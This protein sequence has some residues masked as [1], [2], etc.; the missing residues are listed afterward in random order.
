MQVSQSTARPV[1]YIDQF[2]GKLNVLRAPK[3]RSTLSS[4]WLV[5]LNIEI[6]SLMAFRAV[7][8]WPSQPHVPPGYH[9][10][11]LVG[12]RKISP[13]HYHGVGANF[14]APPAQLPDDGR[15]VISEQ[16]AY[17]IVHPECYRLCLNLQNNHLQAAF[18]QANLTASIVQR[19]P[20]E[21]NSTLKLEVSRHEHH[22]SRNVNLRARFPLR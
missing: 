14:Q 4:H 22:A 21:R 13:A 17:Q 15:K 1:R 19:L 9:L 3:S 7:S 16:R 11:R 8:S 12:R 10:Q 6:C 2:V 20:M 18:L 5:P